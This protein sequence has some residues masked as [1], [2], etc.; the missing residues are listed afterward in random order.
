LNC[1]KILLIVIFYFCVLNH[2]NAEVS[3]QE[4]QSIIEERVYNKNYD[5]KFF[6]AYRE[7]IANYTEIDINYALKLTRQYLDYSI[8]A[9][10]RNVE[11]DAYNKLG[12]YSVVTSD[13]INAIDYFS[14]SMD[15][16]KELKL[17]DAVAFTYNEIANIYLLNKEYEEALTLYNKS[18]SLVRDRKNKF[19]NRQIVERITLSNISLAYSDSKNN[20]M[21]LKYQ[22]SALEVA[23]G[24]NKIED[25]A[26]CYYYKGMI[27]LKDGKID[28]SIANYNM[29]I[30][31]SKKINNYSS[32]SRFY[33]RL[34]LAYCGE[35]NYTDAMKKID[36]AKVYFSKI[37][38]MV[39]YT[40]MQITEAKIYKELGKIDKSIQLANEVVKICDNYNVVLEAIEV[41]KLLSEL[42]ISK[43]NYK[44]A[45]KHLKLHDSLLI[46]SSKNAISFKLAQ[47]KF[48]NSIMEREKLIQIEQSSTKFTSLIRY[49]LIG[50]FLFLGIVVVIIIKRYQTEQKLEQMLLKSEEQ[51]TKENQ[52]KNEIFSVI[53]KDLREPLIEF[54][55][56]LNDVD[57]KMVRMSKR[58][59]DFIFTILKKN[60]NNVYLFLE[61]LLT[62]ANL[63]RGNIYKEIRNV[64]LSKSIKHSLRFVEPLAINKSINIEVNVDE[65]CNVIADDTIMINIVKILL[66]NSIKNSS[67]NSTIKLGVVKSNGII[68]VSVEDKSA[69][70]QNAIIEDILEISKVSYLNQFGISTLGLIIVKQYLNIFNSNLKIECKDELNTY[71]FTFYENTDLII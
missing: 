7:L 15:I 32:I 60:T 34:A 24:Y 21:A 40:R 25:I 38:Y 35:K 37:G 45:L 16:C 64:N 63:Q 3:N 39:E 53:S 20:Y 8:R 57:E 54:Q 2:I 55:S 56:I 31:L 27:Y 28:S 50:L 5:D 6:D 61:N 51:L 17:W 59:I 43:K 42:Y 69:K 68:T 11:Q 70:L 1:F 13:F 33:H 12:E 67:D 4:L 65:S 58:D 14:K 23:K 18:L 10:K 48:R 30:I 62:W 44:N 41:N 46:S 22:D 19:D 71:S 66:Q 49:S 9:K 52:S 26:Q 36:T 47:F 29:A